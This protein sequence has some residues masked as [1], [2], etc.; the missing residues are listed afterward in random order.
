MTQILTQFETI[1][2]LPIWEIKKYFLTFSPKHPVDVVREG[3]QDLE[4][5]T[6]VL[7]GAGVKGVKVNPNFLG[8]AAF[9]DGGGLGIAA[10]HELP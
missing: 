1:L 9:D 2:L 6:G 7:E 10:G 3:R 8:P 4:G 5:M